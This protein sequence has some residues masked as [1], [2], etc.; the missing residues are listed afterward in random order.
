VRHS[1]EDH[2]DALMSRLAIGEREAF[3]PLFRAMYPRALRLAR[4]KLPADQAADVA[5]SILMRVFARAPE[6]QP[7]KA[8]LPWFY[9]IASN[10]LRTL[11]RRNA[12]LARRA[13]DDP[14]DVTACTEDDPERALLERELRESL[15]RAIVSLDDTSAE[16]IRCL[17]DE[18]HRPA[19]NDAAFRKR[20]SR[21]YAKLRILLLRG[22]DAD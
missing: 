1:S 11:T 20:V 14:D 10:E 16:A 22:F 2:L 5:Q 7:G 12:T 17:L 4:V 15:D 6:F 19:V 8:L 3:D 18:R 13:A 9:A 21:A